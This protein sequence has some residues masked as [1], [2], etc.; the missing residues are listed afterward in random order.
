M[1]FQVIVAEAAPALEGHKLALNLSKIS[2]ISVTLIPDSAIYAIMSR[3][4][5]VIF[6]P[7][8]VMA[9]GGAICACG[10]S[11]LASAAK[12]SQG[13]SISSFMQF[14]VSCLCHFCFH[15]FSCHFLGFLGAVGW[16]H[17]NIFVDPII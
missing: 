13:S 5:K 10:H 14:H 11:M 2:N 16:S 3:I 8:A 6:A 4:N 7:Q 12:V 1:L 17:G 9:D 15:Y